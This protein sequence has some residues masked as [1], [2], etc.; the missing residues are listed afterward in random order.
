MLVLKKAQKISAKPGTGEQ[1]VAC[2]NHFILIMEIMNKFSFSNQIEPPQ[3]IWRNKIQK[4][5]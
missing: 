5:R 1:L 4:R 2:Q 3:E